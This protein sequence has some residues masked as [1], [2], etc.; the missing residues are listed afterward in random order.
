MILTGRISESIDTTQSLY[1]GLLDRNLDLLFKLKCRQFVEMVSGC[2]SEVKPSAHSPT[3][4]GK[5]S[6]NASPSRTLSHSSLVSNTSSTSATNG[7]DATD[8]SSPPST[9]DMAP[10]VVGNGVAVVDESMEVED[11]AGAGQS[12]SAHPTSSS[13]ASFSNS[14][15][16]RGN[17]YF[18]LLLSQLT[19]ADFEAIAKLIH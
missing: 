5:S 3:R 17:S 15:S 1:P 13:S 10:A 4:S 6:P 7:F 14:S 11:E 12:S 8:L 18:I 16:S 9:A 2:D 19:R